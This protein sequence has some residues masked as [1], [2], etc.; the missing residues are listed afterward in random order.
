M[1]LQ[2]RALLVLALAVLWNGILAAV[3]LR[4]LRHLGMLRRNYRGDTIVTAGGLLLVVG[5]VPVLLVAA[6]WRVAD[7][8]LAAALALA[9]GLFGTLGFVDDRW[10]SAAAKGLR[11]HLRAFFRERRITSGLFK[12]LGG[13]AAATWISLG[14][15]G[16]HPWKLPLLALIIAL[17]ANAANLLDLRPGRAG[18]VCLVGQMLAL[19]SFVTVGERGSSMAVA[20]VL[21]SSALLQAH[22]ARGWLM[23]GDTG[24]NALGAAAAVSL[25][26]AFPFVWFQITLL[27]VLVGLHVVA[28]RWSLSQIIAG[29]AVLRWLDSLTGVR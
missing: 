24:S 27:L 5:A 7:P 12:A 3:L 25:T 11:G 29:N 22:D 17:G 10:G 8:D 4:F 6:R 23:L 9:L 15:V 20:C 18:A 26:M 19:G 21:V 14:I 28:E 1:S 13:L 16:C 2:A